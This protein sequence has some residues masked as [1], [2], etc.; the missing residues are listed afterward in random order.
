MIRDPRLSWLTG[1]KVSPEGEAGFPLGKWIAISLCI[2]LVCLYFFSST[3][4]TNMIKIPK[5]F[6][7]RVP[8][9]LK[10]FKTIAEA[11]RSRDVS[12]AD[13]V[14]LVKD[15]LADVFGYDKYTEL[16]SEFAIR[17]TYCDLAVKLEGKLSMLIEVK[18]AG[19][20]LNDSHLRQA[21]NYGANQGV[22]W[23]VLTNALEWKLYRVR[24]GQPIS[25]DEVSS[26]SIS[27]VNPKSEDD[28]RRLFLLAREGWA[29]GAMDVF[30][31][32]SQLLNR[33]TV[34]QMLLTEGVLSSIRRELRRLF[35]DVKVESDAIASILQ[36]EVIK[37]D[38]LEGDKWKEAG[39]RV[40]KA[41]SKLARQAAKKISSTGTPGASDEAPTDV[42]TD[43]ETDL[44]EEPVNEEPTQPEPAE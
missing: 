35:P 10:H 17:G 34:T 43:V 7:D 33:Y 6:L 22:E 3:H 23:I 13:T 39:D 18:A 30:H 40:K 5:K 19:V 1:G 15:M 27:T 11:Q 31:Q 32:H 36:A 2:F 16:T 25:H 26:F 9:P 37:R 4:K 38:V 41:T 42:E 24:F 44:E 21:L 12:E 28:L 29:G 8:A 14:T 20:T